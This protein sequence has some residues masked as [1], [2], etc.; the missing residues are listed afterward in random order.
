MSTDQC[1]V[2][3][4]NR[5]SCVAIQSQAIPS[6]PSVNQVAAASIVQHSLSSMWSVECS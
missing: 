4:A 6:A 5:H 1:R 2:T 3:S